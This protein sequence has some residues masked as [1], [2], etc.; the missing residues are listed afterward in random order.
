M[1]RRLIV[2]LLLFASTLAGYSQHVSRHIENASS[3][4]ET[5]HRSK[6]TLGKL[7]KATAITYSVDNGSV[8]D[9]YQYHYTITVTPDSVHVT[10]HTRYGWNKALDKALPITPEAYKK[11]ISALAK[12]K[13]RKT[14][15][16]DPGVGG[17]SESI[18]VKNEKKLFFRGTCGVDLSV[19]KYAVEGLFLSLLTDELKEELQNNTIYLGCSD[20]RRQI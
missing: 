11:F 1:G 5:F 16:V 7:K 2:T 3:E 12:Q 20:E 19:G 15:W 10:V 18:V 17:G 4:N 13:I 8:L 14:P 9:I 6:L